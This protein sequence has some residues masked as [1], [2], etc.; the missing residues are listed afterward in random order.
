[1]HATPYYWL[2]KDSVGAVREQHRT[3][4][5]SEEAEQDAK[6]A[7]GWDDTTWVLRD[8]GYADG[9][10]MKKKWYAEQ[11]ILPLA[12]GGGPNGAL[13][14]TEGRDGVDAQAWRDLAQ[15]FLTGGPTR[16]ERGRRSRR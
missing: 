15:S 14:W 10:E 7:L 12:D 16:P 6:T 13:I 1:M 11:G 3:D 8:P 4:G 5:Y 2:D 9:W